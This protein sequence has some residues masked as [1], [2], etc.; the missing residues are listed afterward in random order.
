MSLLNKYTRTQSQQP[1]TPPIVY[2]ALTLLETLE[3]EEFNL[4]SDLNLVEEAKSHEHDLRLRLNVVQQ[5]LAAFRAL[6]AEPVQETEPAPV[7][8][9]V[10]KAA[11][12]PIERSIASE[13]I[14]SDTG[15][16]DVAHDDFSTFP[17]PK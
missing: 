8:K 6:E 12:K 17:S 3:N 4:Q 14:V 11:K 16:I 1:Q 15:H 5:S 13:P 9:S 2:K 10:R 7:V